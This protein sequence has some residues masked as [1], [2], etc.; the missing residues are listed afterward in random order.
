MKRIAI[1][2]L[3]LLFALCGCKG[4][5][6][7][8]QAGNVFKP[9]EIWPD[10]N[11]VHINAHGG[12]MLQQ[13]DTYYW[14]GEHKTEGEGGNVAQVG[15][16]CYSSKDLYN[17]KDEGIALSVSDDESSPIVKGCILERPKVIFNKKTGR[18]VMWFHLEPKGAG[19]TGAKSGVAVSEKVTGPYKLLSADRP[20]AGFWPKN[21]LD[22]HKGPVP[23]ESK[24]GFGGGGLPA[25]P[26]TLNL[27]GRDFE[28]GQMARDMNLFVDD[29]GKAYH[30]CSS[31]WN[32]TLY[33]SLLTDDYTKPS[34]TY[35]R[36][37]IGQS[38]EAPAVFKRNGHY[39]M[40]SSG[41]TGW[42]PNKAKWAVSDSM[43]G[44][45]ELKDNPCLGRDADKTFYAQST[46][47]LPIEGMQD[48]FIA[49]FDRWNKTD[50]INSR[51][52]W[53]PI[54]FD[55]DRPLIRWADQWSTQTM[56]AVY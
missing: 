33:I 8:S 21:V 15:V 11:G 45:W 25:H 50:L 24:K 17:W 48:Q 40:L 49:M 46:Y 2:P 51:Y 10:N 34:G 18:Y 6:G 20:N 31:E 38:R 19:Y 47:V 3:L 29:D 53:L 56:E 44:V 42:D 5:T 52:V 16:H 54:E 55:G 1:Y 7:T 37:F 41:C 30:I 32:S 4:K 22:I 12:G 13:G 43:M 14:F 35:V 26:D 28:S 27:L 23:E 36:R 39:Y 9:G